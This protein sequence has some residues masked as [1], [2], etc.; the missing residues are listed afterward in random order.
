MAL[1]QDYSDD[2]RLKFSVV[3]TTFPGVATQL[4]LS[5]LCVERCVVVADSV[6]HGNIKRGNILD[7]ILV[8]VSYAALDRPVTRTLDLPIRAQNALE[9][10]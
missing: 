3:V 6:A 1:V 10:S 9:I 5:T 4:H 2:S 8:A 7:H